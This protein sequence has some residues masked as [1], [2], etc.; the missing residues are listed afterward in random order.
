VEEIREI[1]LV[2]GRSQ[3]SEANIRWLLNTLLRKA[4]VTA[5][6]IHPDAAQPVNIQA[7]RGWKF[8]PIKW[9]RKKYL[10]TGRPDY[11]VWY[12]EDE[13]VSVNVVVVEARGG[14]V[15]VDG[16]GT[17]TGRYR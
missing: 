10:L 11:G 5:T 14:G 8:G 12:G 7:E 3:A 15:E 6:T 4:H 13:D 1:N 16:N 9:Q 2:L 17:S